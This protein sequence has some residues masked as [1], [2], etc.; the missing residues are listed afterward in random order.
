M[1]SPATIGADKPPLQLPLGGYF[2]SYVTDQTIDK[3]HSNWYLFGLHIDSPSHEMNRG[4]FISFSCREGQV[5]AW[6]NLK[7][8][9]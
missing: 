9:S 8:I 2:S 4:G 6:P 3:H 7:S 5:Q 1:S